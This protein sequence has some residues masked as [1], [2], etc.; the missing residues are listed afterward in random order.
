MNNADKFKSIV[1][2]IHHLPQEKKNQV[3][4][5]TLGGFKALF[6]NKL[7]NEEWVIEVYSRVVED[8]KK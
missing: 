7:V 4:F 3:L 5:E 2:E 1:A 6:D 8:A